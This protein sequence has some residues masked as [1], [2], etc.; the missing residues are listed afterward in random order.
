MAENE[1]LSR[2]LDVYAERNVRQI[3]SDDV[4]R[5]LRKQGITS[6]EELVAGTLAEFEAGG[7]I[8]KTTF[9]YTQFIYKKS[10]VIDSALLDDIEQRALQRSK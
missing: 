9:I 4:M 5:R 1:R 8:A 7:D 3:S 2:I 10:R 6:L